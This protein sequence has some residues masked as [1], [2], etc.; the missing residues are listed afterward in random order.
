MGLL[1]S[2]G[3]GRHADRTPVAIIGAGALGEHLAKAL[4]GPLDLG[5][6]PLFLVDRDGLAKG[7]SVAGLR[8]Y[9]ADKDIDAIRRRHIQEVIIALPELSGEELAKLYQRYASLGCRV[10]LYESSE[11]AGNGTQRSVVRDF[12]IED[13][14]S[15]KARD[16]TEPGVEDAYEGRTILITGGAGMVGSELCRRLAK[17]RPERL[18]VLD[19]SESSV[20]S[21]QQALLRTYGRELK[22]QAVIGSVRDGKCLEGLFHHYRPEIVFHA[23]THRHVSLME[24]NGP[25]AIKNN[26]FGTR[27]LAEYAEAYHTERFLLIST[28]KAVRPASIVG[29][30]M[31]LAEMVI[32]AHEKSATYFGSIRFG[33]ILDGSGS[34][35]DLFHQQIASGG[36]VTIPDSHATRFLVSAAE[37]AHLIL[38]SALLAQRGNVFFLDLDKPVQLQFL[39]MNTIRIAGLDPETDVPIR[40]TGLAP[41]EKLHSELFHDPHHVTGTDDPRIFVEHGY[42]VSPEELSIRLTLLSDTIANEG[43]LR[44]VLRRVLPDYEPNYIISH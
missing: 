29:A 38:K 39:A 3:G 37:A 44:S 23:A 26:V 9:D 12:T 7:S 4:R 35:L 1:Q 43:N 11:N 14:L 33:N 31:R 5:F 18:I 36:P 16:Y 42:T 10:R 27:T 21:L 34:V 41:G 24:R 15:L 40:V 6:E 13:L 17:A 2:I 20:Y 25:E 8:V 32:E 19:T 30:S 28:D 22:F